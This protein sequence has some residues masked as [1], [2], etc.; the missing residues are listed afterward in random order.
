[1]GAISADGTVGK[2][3]VSLVVNDEV[4]ATRYA[5]CLPAPGKPFTVYGYRLRPYPSF[6]V[7]GH[8]VRAAA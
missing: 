7:N 1:M 4:L 6:L 8:L 5:R 3:Y 2:N